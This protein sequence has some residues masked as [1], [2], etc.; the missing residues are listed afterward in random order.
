MLGALWTYVLTGNGRWVALG[1]VGFAV[2]YRVAR[3]AR[4]RGAAKRGKTADIAKGAVWA[5]QRGLLPPE[6]EDVRTP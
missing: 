6:D 2:V 4:R 3:T 5:A 1:V